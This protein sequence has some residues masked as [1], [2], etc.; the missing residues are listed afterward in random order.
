MFVI[1]GAVPPNASWFCINVQTGLGLASQPGSGGDILLHLRPDFPSRSVIRSSRVNGVWGQQSQPDSFFPL[2]PGSPFELMILIPPQSPSAY[3]PNTVKIAFNGAHFAEHTLPQPSI[4]H[5]I[6]VTI[7]AEPGGLTVHQFQEFFTPSATPVQS[8]A[9]PY[10]PGSGMPMPS[11]SG[12]AVGAASMPGAPYPP[13]TTGYPAGAGYS[14][15][16]PHGAASAPQAK[17]G[18]MMGK[19]LGTAATVPILGGAL[20][21]ASHTGIGKKLTKKM[22]GYPVAAATGMAYPQYPLGGKKASKGG[23]GLGTAAG[24]GAGALG[25]YVLAKKTKKLK[26][27]FKFSHGGRSS[28]SSSSSSSD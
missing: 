18:G 10:P 15:G 14:P 7:E 21:A 5:N 20:A 26:K 24:L 25:A 22:G 27:G 17:Q 12:Y 16:V 2:T 4:P 23:M 8:T 1:H 6:Y 9:A 28:S 11:A 19:I 3:P 13:S